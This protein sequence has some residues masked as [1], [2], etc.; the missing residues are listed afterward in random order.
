MNW[1][2]IIGSGLTL[3]LMSIGFV[4]SFLPGLPGTPLVFAAAVLHRLYFADQG[5]STWVLFILG[6]LMGVS[7]VVDFV[8]SVVGA[9]KLGSTWR[10][11]A[12]ATIGLLGG[13]F[14][15]PLGLVAGP[16]AGAFLGEMAGGREPR[17][18][19]RAGC[20]A[21]LGLLGGAIGKGICSLLMMGLFTFELLLR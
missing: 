7:L 20:G 17:D 12:G 15:L 8:A 3:L 9:K 16:F 19:A 21:I 14:F 1:E 11:M 2:L 4:G 5:S 10:G 13:M 18:A 6:I